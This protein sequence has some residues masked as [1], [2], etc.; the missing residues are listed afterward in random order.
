MSEYFQLQFKMLNRKMIDFGL[1]LLIGYTLLPL[2][3]ILLSNYI[4]SKSQFAT[5]LYGFIIMGFISKLSEPKRNDFLKAIFNKIDYFKVRIIENLICTLPFLIYLVYQ[6]QFFATLIVFILTVLITLFSFDT[7]RNYTIPTP[8]GKNP[9]EFIIGFRKTF[10][11]F[12]IAYFLTYISIKVHNFNLGIF[13]MLLIGIICFSFYT[14]IENE[15]YVWN[16][17]L[18]SKDFLIE[19]V[20]RCL[21]N[22]T[23]LSTPIII[24]LSIFFYNEIDILIVFFVLCYLYLIT[25]IFAKYTSFPNEMNMSQGILIAVSFLF[26]PIILA[27]IPLF[28]S[29][30]IKSLNSI[31]K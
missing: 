4:F 9:F 14:K 23:L 3:F 21:I 5:Y 25:I 18:S 6:K 1:P 31:L 24:A 19:K 8:F 28:Y 2:I 15:Y 12:P 30:S 16:F 17:K 22:F 10:F 29:Q 26:P 20:K 7:T 27:L 13:S 11:V